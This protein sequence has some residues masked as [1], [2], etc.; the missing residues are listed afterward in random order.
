M[1]FFKH[2]SDYKIHLTKHKICGIFKI[3][4]HFIIYYHAYFHP[5]N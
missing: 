3:V 5:Q 1:C 2:K 4:K